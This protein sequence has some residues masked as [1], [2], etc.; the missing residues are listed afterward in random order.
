VRDPLAYNGRRVVV[1][2]AAS[3]IGRATTELLVELGAEVH[4]LDVVPVEVNGLASRTQCD[5]ADPDAVDDAVARIGAV[6]NGLFACAGVPLDHDPLDV[7]LVNFVGLREVAHRTIEKMIDGAAIVSMGSVGG[8]GWRE[9]RESLEPL[10]ATDGFVAARAWCEANRGVYED[11]A[12]GASKRAVN[13][14]TRRSAGPLLERGVRVNCVNAGPVDT[15]LFGPFRET[16]GEEALLGAFP[17]HRYAAA[18]EM[19]W[20]LVWLNS[21]RASYVTGVGLDVDGGFAAV[22]GAD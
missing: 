18:E 3:G 17:I 2:G 14:W 6:L 5:V 22:H 12:Y 16:Y 15:P 13:L 7:M 20:A 21:P 10:L 4:A 1:T 19:A 11:D 8:Y 9:A